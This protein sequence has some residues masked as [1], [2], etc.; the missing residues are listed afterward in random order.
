MNTKRVIIITGAGG[1]VGSALTKRF[2]A[3]G[4]SVLATDAVAGGLER[5]KEAH[6]SEP[7]VT[8]VTDIS[9]PDQVTALVELARKRFG[10]VHVLVNCA[11]FFPFVTFEDMTLRDWQKVIDINLTGSYLITHAL[12]PLMKDKGWGRVINFSS[13]SVLDGTKGQLH[14]VSAK[15]G[16]IGFTRSLARELGDHN[17][18]VNAVVP[19]LT[20]TK[21]VTDNFP[22]ELLK[23]Q[24]QRRAIKREEV[25]EDL[26][27]PVFFLA[28]PDS[29]FVTGQTLN[30]DGGNFMI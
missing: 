15:A 6:A 9:S 29:D 3:N 25:A 10:E 24:I 4:D 8:S 16:M 2:L 1:G 11:G 14:Y 26:A 21:A 28:S 27:G 23:A 5:L 30:V 18:T 19:G 17:I 22:P 13:G 7:L 12:I 20:A